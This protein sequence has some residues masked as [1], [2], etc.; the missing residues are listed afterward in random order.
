LQQELKRKAC[1]ILSKFTAQNV[2]TIVS[3]SFYY[4][5]QERIQVAV[6]LLIENTWQVEL[7][8]IGFFVPRPPS[9]RENEKPMVFNSLLPAVVA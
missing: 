4:S 7:K 6:C 3:I 8:T 5:S 9:P 2:D 1:G